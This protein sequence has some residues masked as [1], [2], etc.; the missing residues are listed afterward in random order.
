MIAETLI[1]R[2]GRGNAADA[3]GRLAIKE[4]RSS[5][6]QWLG[7]MMIIT[8]FIILSFYSMIAGWALD[9]IFLSASGTFSGASTNFINGLFSDLI[10][11]PGLLILCH[12]AIMLATTAVI[13]L[14]VKNGIERATSLL[15][16]MMI[17]LL[18]ILIGYA[19]NTGFF[20]HGLS[21]L[22][23]P[24]FS[25]L[26][27]KS[28]LI[29]LGHAFF[30]LSL[31]MGII[32]TYGSYLKNTVCL[33]KT[34]IFIAIIDTIVALLAG[35]A[36]FPL[37]FA[38]DLT[39]AMG[40]SLIFQTLPLAF[41]HMP[42]G[43]LFATLFFIMLL[44][45]AFTSTISL[46]EP[47]VAWVN[48]R[49]NLSRLTASMVCGFAIWLLGL[50]S[51]FSFNIWADVKFFG[52]TIFDNLD[53]LASNIML[54]LGGLGVAIF[55]GYILSKH[56]TEQELGADGRWYYNCWRFTLRYITPVAIL[57]VFLSVINVI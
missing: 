21:F 17:I 53:F 4:K 36:I 26:T 28:A 38:N 27:G 3:L 37:V 50:A 47:V 33:V 12:S 7:I 29:A 22:F 43:S 1:G 32:I 31:G 19:I 42:L 13:G 56:T 23:S 2:R 49:S 18:V 44:F 10:S 14:G 57:L 55:A 16:P 41:G 51:V 40:P 5:R 11:R 34:S 24:D 8:C 30:T 52:K 35:L 25:K 48:E 6:W 46:L 9:Y 15:L 54:P 20:G 45:A 39:P